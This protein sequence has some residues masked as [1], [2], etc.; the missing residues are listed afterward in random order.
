[1]GSEN[2]MKLYA[3]IEDLGDNS[4]PP[5]VILKSASLPRVI[6]MRQT[7]IDNINQY[8]K[9]RD[10][11]LQTIYTNTNVN[12]KSDLDEIMEY[13]EGSE[14]FKPALPQ[15]M[16]GVCNFSSNFTESSDEELNIWNCVN[17]VEVSPLILNATYHIEIM[18]D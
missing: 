6:N 7:Y 15:K 9:C 3:L 8:K 11:M 16:K 14:C 12:E 17:R 10:C 2:N 1:M 13:P 18:K 4:I 5:R